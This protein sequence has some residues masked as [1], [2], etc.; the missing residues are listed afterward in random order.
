MPSLHDG[1]FSVRDFGAKGNGI[2]DDTAAIQAAVDWPPG[3]NRGTIYFPVGNYRITAPIRFRT[4]LN[5]ACLG[6]PGAT[7]SGNFDDFLLKRTQESPSESIHSIEN[8]QL[9]NSH[10]SGKG[11]ALNGCIGR[12]ANCYISAWHGIETYNSHSVLIDSCTIEAAEASASSVGVI[13]GSATTIVSIA[14]SGYNHGIRHSDAGLIVYGGYF[15]AN[16][17]GIIVGVDE[18][19]DSF[20]STGFDISS[21]SMESNTTGIY[22]SEGASGVISGV[23]IGGDIRMEYGLR[24]GWCR[25]VVVQGVR[26]RG[27]KG[28]AKAGIAIE[29]PTRTTFIGVHCA[30]PKQW[31][32][33]VARRAH[34]TFL[35]TN[36]P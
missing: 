3:L 8:L 17:V 32:L 28:F 22:V 27:T 1:V 35:Q 21:A 18:N 2:Q 4:N 14:V 36:K 5:I 24:L 6:D 20:R 12:I 7:I 10:K 15:E 23:S 26:V 13:A 11:I 30:P 9:I 16:A 25:D 33:P 34:L 31:S 19:G 29:V